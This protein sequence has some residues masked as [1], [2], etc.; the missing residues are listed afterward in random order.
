M[1]KI[2]YFLISRELGKDEHASFLGEF[3]NYDEACNVLTEASCLGK[4]DFVKSLFIFF[5]S[6]SR[7]VGKSAVV[8]AAA[9][10]LEAK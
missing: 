6:D 8:D 1:E 5:A 9:L 10:I 2:E 3:S 7:Q 4:Y